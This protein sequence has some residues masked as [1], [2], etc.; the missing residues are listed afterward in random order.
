MQDHAMQAASALRDSAAGGRKRWTALIDEIVA[1]SW[2]NPDTGRAVATPYRS[3]VIDDSLDGRE[4]ALVRPLGL[5][6]RLAV[7]AADAPYEAM[8]RRVVRAL[9]AQIRS[10]SRRARGGQ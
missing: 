3:I 9:C 7:V 8:G 2:V 1:G 10:A 5:G 6:A 4:A